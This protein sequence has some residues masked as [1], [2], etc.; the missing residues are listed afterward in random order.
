MR[1]AGPPIA[2]AVLNWLVVDL[3]RVAHQMRAHVSAVSALIASLQLPSTQRALVISMDGAGGP[4]AGV[5]L[6]PVTRRFVLPAVGGDPSA[7]RARASCRLL[8]SLAA[9]PSSKGAARR[10]VDALVPIVPADPIASC[11]I[12]SEYLLNDTR[13][14]S[15]IR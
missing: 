12:A 5:D 9:W 4:Y 7:R 11:G 13:A 6:V 10:R 1:T 14:R 8:R 3:L 15:A 2:S